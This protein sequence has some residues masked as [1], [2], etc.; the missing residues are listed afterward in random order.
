M[1]SL[2]RWLASRVRVKVKKHRRIK[3]DDK[4]AMFQ[5]LATLVVSGTPLMQALQICSQQSDSRVMQSVL[6]DVAGMVASGSTLRDAMADYPK[7]FEQHWLGVIHSGETAGGLA[8]V[9][10]DLSRQIGEYRD[11]RR[12][13]LGAL[14]YPVT[15]V[16]VATSAVVTMLV[17]VVP[18]FAKMFHEMG[19][20]LPGITKAVI[21]ASNSAAHYG[22]FILGLIFG[23]ALIV[24]HLLK[25]EPGL[26]AVSA[27]CLA[28]PI[29]ASVVLNSAMYR[30]AAQ[31]GLLLKSGVA[32]LDMIEGVE[33]VFHRNPVYRDALRIVQRRVASGRS[34]ADALEQTGLFTG[35]VI[36]MVRTGEESGRLA[37]VMEQLA[38]Y[39]RDKAAA[40]ISGA[41]KLLEPAI[42]VVVGSLI[43]AIMLAI[44]MPMFELSGKIH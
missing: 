3:L 17:C 29:T 11:T 35:L 10:Q 16:I 34:L 2:D 6:A 41:T 5:Q 24:R 15:L 23:V 31:A 7:V 18:T 8:T 43:A 42:I 27:L 32:M 14:I 4:V 38:P 37:G 22:P 1:M 26:R 19:A 40:S 12:K 30:F 44:Y 39:Y 13:L 36:N 20:E 33:G 28:N 25:R 21:S 9:L